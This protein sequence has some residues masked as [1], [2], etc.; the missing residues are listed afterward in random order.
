MA[1]KPEA[2]RT[3]LER[4]QHVLT[5]AKQGKAV[6]VLVT[7]TTEGML[8]LTSVNADKEGS[9]ELLTQ[10]LAFVAPDTDDEEDAQQ[11]HTVH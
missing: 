9:I 10:A 3:A 7:A 8:I 4:A 1:E 11:T 6:V 5:L 2:V